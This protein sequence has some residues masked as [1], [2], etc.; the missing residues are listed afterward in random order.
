MDGANARSTRSALAAHGGRGGRGGA[1]GGR[2]GGRLAASA[3]E[4][5]VEGDVSDESAEP[6]AADADVQEQLAA[7][8]ERLTELSVG[9]TA[10]T[11]VV[12]DQTAALASQGKL[13]A[14]SL[15]AQN[16]ALAAA[17]KSSE[18]FQA[19]ALAAN[20]ALSV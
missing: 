9:N 7:L 20:A 15:F 6:P 10:L 14:D 1:R 18:E 2:A 5:T 4:P 13:V 8:T 19:R 12:A 16:Q 17:Q 11:S 3:T